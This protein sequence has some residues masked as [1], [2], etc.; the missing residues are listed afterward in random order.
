MNVRYDRM[1]RW[2]FLSIGFVFCIAML[3]TSLAVLVYDYKIPEAELIKSSLG[4]MLT[5]ITFFI[6][7]IVF[8]IELIKTRKKQS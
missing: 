3:G 1:L 7:S 8:Y 2:D 5:C 6:T 4:L